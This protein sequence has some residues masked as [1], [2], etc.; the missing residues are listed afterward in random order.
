MKKNGKGLSFGLF[1]LPD[2]MMINLG[3]NSSP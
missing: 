3:F 1:C 2:I